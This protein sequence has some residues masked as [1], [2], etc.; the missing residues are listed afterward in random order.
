M[1]PSEQTPTSFFTTLTAFVA[2]YYCYRALFLRIDDIIG[3]ILQRLEDYPDAEVLTL[4]KRYIIAAAWVAGSAIVEHAELYG[5]DV[6][7]GGH[8]F[9]VAALALLLLIAHVTHKLGGEQEGT[10]AQRAGHV[11]VRTFTEGGDQAC[12]ASFGELCEDSRECERCVWVSLE[13]IERAERQAEA[14]EQ[15]LL[16]LAAMGV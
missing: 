3:D 15:D 7:F 13:E 5:S 1:D 8:C 14:D 11:R 9:C 2:T 12:G 16:G 6:G 4:T 10:L